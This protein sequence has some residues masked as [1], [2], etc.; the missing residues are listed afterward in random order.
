MASGAEVI[1]TKGNVCS[2]AAE[3]TPQADKRIERTAASERNLMDFI[4]GR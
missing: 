3:V 4:W 2:D 1:R